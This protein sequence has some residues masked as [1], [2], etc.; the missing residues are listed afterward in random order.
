MVSLT[1]RLENIGDP[2]EHLLSLLDADSLV[3]MWNVSP[4]WR[5]VLLRF[6]T[7]IKRRFVKEIAIINNIRLNSKARMLLCHPHHSFE[8]SR[9]VQNARQEWNIYSLIQPEADIPSEVRFLM[10][11]QED[12][13][14]IPAKTLFLHTADLEECF[15]TKIIRFG[16]IYSKLLEDAKLEEGRELELQVLIKDFARSHR[17]RLDY[18]YTLILYVA[19]CRPLGF[20]DK[21]SQEANIALV[22]QFLEPQMTKTIDSQHSTHRL[23]QLF[24][25]LSAHS[26][27]LAMELCTK[28]IDVGFKIVKAS[29]PMRHVH[30]DGC[31]LWVL[32]RALDYLSRNKPTPDFRERVEKQ[33]KK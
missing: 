16:T 15:T 21:K 13:Q 5:Q 1:F 26:D 20:D 33:L 29:C 31:K 19:Q 14:A 28:L 23:H 18:I 3:A 8:L 4:L 12:C 22:L 11:S 30:D 24:E 32:M 17:H 2:T 9:A 7:Q 25:A 27:S 10:K 6:H